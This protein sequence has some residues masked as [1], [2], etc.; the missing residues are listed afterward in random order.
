MSEEKLDVST[1]ITKL[2]ESSGSGER[3]E[4]LPIPDA[5]IMTPEGLISLS[6]FMEKIQTP[7]YVA[8][9][10]KH[11][12][13]AITPA[14]KREGLEE[15]HSGEAPL[16]M[17]RELIRVEVAQANEKLRQLSK[18][19]LIR[20][21]RG[22][23]Y[24]IASTSKKLIMNNLI[25]IQGLMK[26]TALMAF[27]D[28]VKKVDASG[29]PL[30][31]A[32]NRLEGDLARAEHMETVKHNM[33]V[34][35]MLII[36]VVA[37]V[38]AAV[39]IFH[40]LSSV[41]KKVWDVLRILVKNNIVFNPQKPESDTI[42]ISHLERYELVGVYSRYR[43]ADGTEFSVQ[44]PDGGIESA[45]AGSNFTLTKFA[46]TSLLKIYVDDLYIGM[47]F[48][49][50]NWCVTALHVAARA[51]KGCAVT[52]EAVSSGKTF[53]F[54]IP[55]NKTL[56]IENNLKK[57]GFVGI[58][59]TP[60]ADTALIVPPSNIWS[61]LGDPSSVTP[62]RLY[63]GV[64]YA[65]TCFGTWSSEPKNLYETHGNIYENNGFT[66]LH[67]ASSRR[68]FSGTP[69]YIG[70]TM[71]RQQVAF[72]HYLGSKKSTEPNTAT[73]FYYVAQWI[74]IVMDSESAPR[75]LKEDSYEYFIK[76][77]QRHR[78]EIND[79]DECNKIQSPYDAGEFFIMINGKLR[80]FQ[81]EELD[82]IADQRL[83]NE[84]MGEVFREYEDRGLEYYADSAQGKGYD[85]DAERQEVEERI[86][87]HGRGKDN[88]F[89]DPESAEYEPSEASDEEEEEIPKKEATKK[90]IAKVAPTRK[91]KDIPDGLKIKTKVKTP[92]VIKE[93]A[94]VEQKTEKVDPA[95]E[96]K[97]L[98]ARE[99]KKLEDKL[100]KLTKSQPFLKGNQKTQVPPSKSVCGSKK[101]KKNSQL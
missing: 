85:S 101:K 65:I 17:F 99:I 36:T 18:N 34:L 43:K 2:S 26:W 86:S 3:R 94:V 57:K 24:P 45:Q 35:C 46:P 98:I 9:A 59:V 53:S 71:G 74:D 68:G 13:E 20:F 81:A 6:A 37:A 77:A 32:L 11:L 19:E 15:P 40:A 64:S 25:R 62:A 31:S 92:K 58:E 95:I 1:S 22:L 60:F 54:I 87:G 8:A 14:A 39:F 91:E 78:D 23:G 63:K 4:P 42:D 82:L 66:I 52:L 44:V 83:S 90:V 61:K 48:R 100:K 76:F 30:L 80:T 38:T 75:N 5:D 96:A 47:G 7:S 89:G 70:S 51:E 12:D 49:Y 10:S 56:S 88:P 84:Q 33:F 69:G 72:V 50:K 97:A 73:A 27:A 21:L 28:A 16:E 41:L 55:E 29:I 67:T 79:S 93:S